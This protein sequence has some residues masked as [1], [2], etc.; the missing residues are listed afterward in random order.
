MLY[1]IANNFPHAILKAKEP[2]FISIYEPTVRY[3]PENKQNLIRYKNL[4]KNIEDSLKEKYPKKEISSIMEPLYALADDEMFWVNMYDGLAVLAAEGQ[5]VVYKLQRPVKELAI[6]ADSFHIKPLIRIFQSAD[7]YHVLGLNRKEFMLYEGNM[8][9]FEEVQ[10]EPGT[11]RTIE[12]A[13][14]IE[15][16]EPLIAPRP[17]TSTG[18]STIFYGYDDKSEMI[19]EDTEKFFRFIDKLVYEKYSRQAQLPL[20]VVA[21]PEYYSLFKEISRNPFLIEQA[22]KVDYTA[23]TKEDLKKKVWEA[24]EPLYRQKIK[25]LV[26]RFGEAKAKGLGSDDIAKV[27]MAAF[28]FNID[29]ILIEEDRIVPGKVDP[30]SG[31]IKEGNSVGPLADDVLDDLGEMVFK[32]RGNIVV[33]PKEQMPTDTGVAAIFKY[34]M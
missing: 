28:Q 2:P 24:I 17:R 9:G 6:A 29:T 1:E 15:D 25:E 31:E 4:I 18:G 33:L 20:L 23:L 22:V 19:K 8:Y 3:R 13:L 27:A 5:C 12:E 26:E 16:E 32:N 34:K 14:G 7:R 11:P 21:L 10:F 30:L